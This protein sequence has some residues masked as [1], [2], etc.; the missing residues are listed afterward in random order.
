MS[1]K[2][3]DELFLKIAERY[4]N[5]ESAKALSLE[6]GVVKGTLI[7]RFQRY[8]IPNSKTPKD[9]VLKPQIKKHI[10]DANE[11][12]KIIAL[13]KNGA[14]ISEIIRQTKFARK[15][16]EKCLKEHNLQFKRLNT[17]KLRLHLG[18]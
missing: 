11:S 17:T 13:N 18:I 5:G 8:G 10:L 6:F 16:I 4:K 15:T 14:S 9:I 3:S 2:I 7:S 12:N 1:K